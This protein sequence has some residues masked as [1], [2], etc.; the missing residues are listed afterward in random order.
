MDPMLEN[1]V[2]LDSLGED[3]MV[4]H[5][6]WS[7]EPP[8]DLEDEDDPQVFIYRAL[9]KELGPYFIEV[10]TRA[11]ARSH[12]NLQSDPDDHDFEYMRDE[13]AHRH[14]M[15]VA[16]AIHELVQKGMSDGTD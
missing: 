10:A 7:E 13:R 3:Q 8:F 16:V 15:E 14:A 12:P 2:T 5:G 9:C 11:L 1:P 6:A 4:P